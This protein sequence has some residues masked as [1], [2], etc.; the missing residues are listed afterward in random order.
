VAVADARL[1]RISEPTVREL[2][3]SSGRAVQTVG[4]IAIATLAER[5]LSM[6]S[7]GSDGA[8]ADR[9]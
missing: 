6:I 5:I 8:S 3:D 4:Q 7:S 1:D 2:P 9:N